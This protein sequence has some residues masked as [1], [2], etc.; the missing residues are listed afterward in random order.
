PEPYASHRY[1]LWPT[2]R[3]SYPVRRCRRTA[4]AEYH[5][6]LWWRPCPRQP[7]DLVV[8][9]KDVKAKIRRVIGELEAIEQQSDPIF[10]AP[11]DVYI[12]SWRA[13]CSAC[14]WLGGDRE[15]KVGYQ[16][17]EPMKKE[18][19]VGNRHHCR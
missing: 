2:L 8:V 9:T 11:R 6:N 7:I 18:A 3:V 5:K 16:L 13:R 10:A 14:A 17:F 19:N 4:T 1:E 12:D 15:T